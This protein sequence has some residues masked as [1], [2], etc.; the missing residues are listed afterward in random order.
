[1]QEYS[2][3]K[4]K[5]TPNKCFHKYEKCNEVDNIPLKKFDIN[6][7]NVNTFNKFINVSYLQWV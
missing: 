2:Y 7:S 3:N 4:L 1:M 5:E 6:Q